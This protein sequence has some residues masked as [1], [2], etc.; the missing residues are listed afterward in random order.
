MS[1][2]CVGTVQDIPPSSGRLFR[3]KD[4]EEIGVFHLSDGRFFATENRCPH[5]GGPLSEGMISG[6]FV[7]CPLHDRKINLENGQV[8]FPDQGC[9]K[10]F[11]TKIV[12][13]WVFVDR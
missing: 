3:G 7:F 9:V 10:T 6:H 1:W 11:P 13:G 4:G 12:E 5:R 8:Q 2:I